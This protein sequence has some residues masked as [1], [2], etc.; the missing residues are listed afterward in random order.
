MATVGIGSPARWRQAATMRVELWCLLLGDD[1][2]LADLRAS[3]S[4][5]QYEPPTITR[6]DHEPEEQGSGAP[7]AEEAGDSHE[8]TRRARQAGLRSSSC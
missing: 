3:L 2:G 7:A 4:L 1:L 5:N 6:R 8:Q